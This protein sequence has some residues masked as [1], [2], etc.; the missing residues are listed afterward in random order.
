MGAN[1]VES[2]VATMS[3]EAPSED[4]G[5]RKTSL[6][7][8]TVESPMLPFFPNSQATVISVGDGLI[9]LHDSRAQPFSKVSITPY[10]RGDFFRKLPHPLETLMKDLPTVDSFHMICCTLSAVRRLKRDVQLCLRSSGFGGVTAA[11]FGGDG[12]SSQ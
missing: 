4:F 9:Q 8:N 7:T 6:Y 1:I 3:N 5:V 2:H 11:L 12:F 10:M